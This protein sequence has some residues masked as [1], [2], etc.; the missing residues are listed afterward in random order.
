MQTDGERFWT[1][2]K[3]L[4]WWVIRLIYN[5]DYTFIVFCARS[6]IINK[7]LSLTFTVICERLHQMQLID[8]TYTIEEFQFMR[9]HYQR[10]LYQLLAVAKSSTQSSGGRSILLPLPR[11]GI[12]V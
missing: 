7:V 12:T 9:S 2:E 11:F 1:A 4:S 8:D 5:M 3:A 6:Y 10:A